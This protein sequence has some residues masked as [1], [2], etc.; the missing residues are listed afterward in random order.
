[1]ARAIKLT[2]VVIICSNIIYTL[3]STLYLHAF[4][5]ES[6]FLV[7]LGRVDSL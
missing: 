1:M 4:A 7:F 5:A 3:R 2:H 6:G